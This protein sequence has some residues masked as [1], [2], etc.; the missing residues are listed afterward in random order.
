MIQQHSTA[1]IASTLC[2]Q[3]QNL[4][5][6]LNQLKI[7][8]SNRTQVSTNESIL[9]E[10]EFLKPDF[11]FYSPISQGSINVTDL[12]VRIKQVSPN[13]KIILTVNENDSTKVLNYLLANADA[14]IWNENLIESVEFAI[15]QLRKDQS[16]FCG[17]TLL[18]LKTLLLGRRT[19]EKSSHD[20]LEL[21]TER[22]KEVLFSLTQGINYK[23][24]SKLL[25]ISESTVKTHINNIFTKLNVNDRTQA[26]LYALRHGIENLAKKPGIL[27]NLTNEKIEK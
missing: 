15:K 4:L 16:F 13:T 9:N 5:Q 2:L 26:V 7:L 27:K 24:I 19:E 12:I 23:Q 1:L 17:R 8:V 14:M 10:I 11:L 22:E 25:F 20:L 3:N 18:E 6:L 21:L